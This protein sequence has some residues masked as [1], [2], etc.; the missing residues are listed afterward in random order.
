MAPRPGDI[1]FAPMLSLLLALCAPPALAASTAP[2][3]VEAP[4]TGGVVVAA[5]LRQ[6]YVAGFPM[7][8]RITVRNDGDAPTSFPDLASRPW[9]VRFLVDGPGGQKSER[10][11]TPPAIDTSPGTMRGALRCRAVEP[12]LRGGC[13]RCA[14]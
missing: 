14:C 13:F 4:A 2:A 6:D 8:V 11:T 1:V 10:Y 7:L 3:L 12:A 5:D 9:L